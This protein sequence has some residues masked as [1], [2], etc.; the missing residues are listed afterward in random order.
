MT[1]GLLKEIPG[2]IPFNITHS[3]YEQTLIIPVAIAGFIT[4]FPNGKSNFTYF[5]KTLNTLL[6]RTVKN[7]VCTMI[8]ETLEII[9]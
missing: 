7:Q 6:I 3:V 5:F 1:K 8:S 4:N 9:Y 2:I